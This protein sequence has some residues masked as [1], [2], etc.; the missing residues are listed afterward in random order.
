LKEE[1]KSINGKLDYKIIYSYN[2]EGLLI[3]EKRLNNSGEVEV[4]YV[5]EYSYY[6]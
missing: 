5:T 2:K 4:E 1:A 6:Q 3:N